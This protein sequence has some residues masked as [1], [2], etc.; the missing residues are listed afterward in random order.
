[1][2]DYRYYTVSVPEQ[3][4]TTDRHDQQRNVPDSGSVSGGQTSVIP[5]GLSAGERRLRVQYRGHNDDLMG[6]MIRSLAQSSGI[7]S[8]PVYGVDPSGNHVRTPKDG[9]YALRNVQQEIPDPQNGN[10]PTATLAAKK[11]GTTRSHWRYLTF[12]DTTLDNR[13]GSSTTSKLVGVP[14]NAT[15]VR[16]Y[17]RE[18]DL[19]AA[20]VAST[21]T[22]EF[23]DVD[24]YDYTAAGTSYDSMVYTVPYDEEGKT[25]ISVWD[26]RGNASKTDTVAGETV[27]D[28]TKVFHTS[29]EFDGAVVASNGKVRLTM[30]D[31]ANTQ[32]AETY[33]GGSWSD[34]GLPSNSWQIYDVDLYSIDESA[35]KGQTIWEDS[36]NGDTYTLNFIL[37]RG[38]TGIRFYVPDNL[39]GTAGSLPTGLDNLLNPIADTNVIDMNVQQDVKSRDEVR[40]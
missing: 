9:Y 18:T 30:D 25:D 34:A 15:K 27:L 3:A 37:A 12:K 33:S 29:H 10:F 22:T 23:G 39:S 17:D 24:M 36:S 21:V 40:P 38:D 6:E 13:Y 11:I 28:W 32:S 16:W 7:E 5:L 35:V 20:T 31:S 19:Q 1:M 26:T 14:A 8:V 2:T 4:V